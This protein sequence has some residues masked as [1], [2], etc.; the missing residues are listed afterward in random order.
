M[1]SCFLTPLGW[2]SGEG[3]G[4]GVEGY[5]QAVDPLRAQDR[6]EVRAAGCEFA[7]RTV[8]IN[9]DDLPGSAI[10]PQQIADMA[11]RLTMS[12]VTTALGH[13]AVALFVARAKTSH[14]NFPLNGARTYRRLLR[15]ADTSMASRSPSGSRL[16]VARLL[17]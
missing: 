10:L 13:G 6:T 16:F 5:D 15:S 9:A 2:A 17:A 4:L 1:R 3:I 11:I 7:D 8:H 12:L 14:V